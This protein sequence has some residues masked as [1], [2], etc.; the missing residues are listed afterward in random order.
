MARKKK[1]NQTNFSTNKHMRTSIGCSPHSRPKNKHKRRNCKR[2][3]G[4][5]R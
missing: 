3:R 5:G 4:Q 2:Y 1:V